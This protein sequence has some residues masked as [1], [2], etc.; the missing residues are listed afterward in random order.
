MIVISV[1][2]DYIRRHV[3]RLLLSDVMLIIYNI[4][5]TH[6]VFLYNR[7][8]RV[9]IC[10]SHSILLI[11]VYGFD[12]HRQLRVSG[13][14]INQDVDI[15]GSI[16]CLAWHYSSFLQ[17]THRRSATQLYTIVDS[18]VLANSDVLFS[19]STD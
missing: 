16:V 14:Y 19:P 13:T 10:K 11:D 15:K 3:T 8:V 4:D 18:S 12:S 6:D 1:L 2:C 5:M 17:I 9:L 7:C